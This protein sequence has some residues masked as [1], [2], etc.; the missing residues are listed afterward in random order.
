MPIYEFHCRKCGNDF[1]LVRPV[2]KMDQ[3]APCTACKSRATSR[4]LSVFTFSRMTR[5]KAIDGDAE[6]DEY[7]ASYTDHSDDDDWADY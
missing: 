1:E 4:K 7:E 3:A 2:S 5:P 6:P